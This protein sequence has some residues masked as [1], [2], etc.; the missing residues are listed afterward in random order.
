MSQKDYS[1]YEENFTM[2]RKH[3]FIRAE[4][5][6]DT[7]MYANTLE[8]DIFYKKHNYNELLKTTDIKEQVFE[9]SC[10]IEVFNGDTI[11]CAKRYNNSLAINMASEYKAGG[12]VTKG[13]CA[14][15]SL[16]IRS[17][18]FKFLPQLLYPLKPDE[19]VYSKNVT[20]F[21]DI[22][23]EY[24]ENNFKQSFVALPAIRYPKLIN[25]KYTKDDYEI[26]MKKIEMLFLIGIKYKHDVLILGALGTGC[27]KNRPDE[28]AKIFKILIEKYRFHFKK[29]LFAVYSKKDINFA[30][31]K[32]ILT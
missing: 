6:K 27:F 14:Q 28:V 13:S 15:E 30:V 4:K 10:S 3:H 9:E 29:I 24:L 21:K 5:Y 8:E 17:S 23:L 19:I 11:E 26:M 12:G 31:F 1:K 16:F 2:Y 32:K 20:I 18:Y 22:K 25:N 7:M